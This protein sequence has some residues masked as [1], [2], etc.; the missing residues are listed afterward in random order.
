MCYNM[1]VLIWK[2]FFSEKHHVQ[3]KFVMQVYLFLSNANCVRWLTLSVS[4]L[5][6]SFNFLPNEIAKYLVVLTNSSI[7]IEL[8]KADFEHLEP[9]WMGSRYFKE[10]DTSRIIGKDETTL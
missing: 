3:F 6:F 4:F 10:H 1:E 7:I 9:V 8:W 5:I 2:V